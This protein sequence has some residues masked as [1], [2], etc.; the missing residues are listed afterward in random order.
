MKSSD[1]KGIAVV[2]I[3]TG[4]KLGTVSEILLKPQ[5][6]QIS[7]FTIETGGGSG[8]L[9][10]QPSSP[11]E[12]SAADVHAVGPDALTVQDASVLREA[13]GGGETLA[14]TAIMDE[15]VVTEGGTFVG[16]VA[17][18]EFDETTMA[19]N[20]LEVSS[21]FFT[22]NQVVDRADFI[23]IGDELII[24]SDSVC[25]EPPPAETEPASET[26]S[27][28]GVVTEVYGGRGASAN[29]Q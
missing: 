24:V 12:L 16:K 19:V 5:A 17:A 13:P 18:L 27:T 28:P 10:G 20:G 7:A 6:D 21:G 22:S 26:E 23:T 2:S 8:M 4:E 15:K 29:E 3:G 9:S 1:I 25:A 14:L 11:K